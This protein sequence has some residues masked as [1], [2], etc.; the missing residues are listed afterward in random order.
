M[1]NARRDAGACI[2]RAR[3]LAMLNVMGILRVRHARRL[4]MS[5]AAI[6]GAHTNALNRVLRAR[7]RN[8]CRHVRIALAR[9]PAPRP[10]IIFHALCAAR[11]YS[12]VA[13]NARLSAGN[14]ALRATFAR[15]AHRKA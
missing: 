3:M 14:R 7:C 13:T 4:A 15:H 10:A 2:P 11:K 1:A 12:R 8:A 9:C 5:S 6:P